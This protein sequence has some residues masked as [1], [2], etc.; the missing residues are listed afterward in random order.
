MKAT[1]MIG[2]ILIALT[3][4]WQAC[5]NAQGN[6]SKNATTSEKKAS[7]KDLG[8]GNVKS[9]MKSQYDV[10]KRK[11]ETKYQLQF[12][13]DMEVGDI[14]ADKKL[15]VGR[16]EDYTGDVPNMAAEKIADNYE[17]IKGEKIYYLDPYNRWVLIGQDFWG[18]KQN[19]VSGVF[20]MAPP[21][22]FVAGADITI[23]RDPMALIKTDYG[24]V[25]LAA[26]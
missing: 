14:T 8:F 13:S 23:K 11:W 1:T 9:V 12:L 22:L 18:S 26:W 19:T 7:L 4:T 5:T 6:M 17:R 16:S 10:E 3:L 21:E 24:Y 25:I 2:L 20:V 15:I